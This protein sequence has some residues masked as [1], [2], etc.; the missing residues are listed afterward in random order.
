MCICIFSASSSCN[1]A[2]FD[3]VVE[4]IKN[5]HGGNECPWSTAQ[6][7]GAF[8]TYL[9]SLKDTQRRKRLPGR[10]DHNTVCRRQGRLKEKIARRKAAVDTL[11][12]ED[13]KKER[14]KKFLI[15]DYTSS[16][17]S[18]MSEDENGLDVKRFVTK[19]LSWEGVKLTEL[20]NFLDL[21]YNRSLSPHLKNLQTERV[22]GNKVSLRGSPPCA[23][24]WTVRPSPLATSSPAREGRNM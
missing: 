13:S 11:D 16:D 20:K 12:W 9:R 18:E 4:A 21:A 2:A 3:L 8:V 23:P 7:R 24:K 10:L 14:C 5:D 6:L 17:E 19:R 1:K 22:V 15:A